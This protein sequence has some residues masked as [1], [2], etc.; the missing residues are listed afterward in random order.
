M[1][2]S[3]CRVTMRDGVQ[4]YTSVIKPQEKGK[5]PIVLIRNPYSVRGGTQETVDDLLNGPLKTE[6]TDF[7]ENGYCLVIQHC[8]GTGSSEGE[9]VHSLKECDDACDTLDWIRRQDFYAKEIYRFGGSYLGF[10]SLVDA[11]MHHEDVKGAVVYAP[12]M[13]FDLSQ[14]NGVFDIGWRGLW[15]A[16]MESTCAEKKGEINKDLNMFRTFPQRDWGKLLVGHEDY[17]FTI[18]NAHPFHD[19]PF[20]RSPEAPG[21]EIYESLETLQIPT[22]FISG[23]FDVF[24]MSNQKAW[25]E[26]IPKEIRSKCA[27]IIHPYGHST[28]HIQEQ[29]AAFEMDGSEMTTLSQHYAVNWFNHLRVGEPLQNVKEG[30]I[31]FFPEA[32]QNKWYYEK[33]PLSEGEEMKTYFLNIGRVLGDVPDKTEEITFLYNPYNPAI[34]VSPCERANGAPGF[35]RSKYEPFDPIMQEQDVPNSRYDIISFTGKKITEHCFV[36]GAIRGRLIVKSDCEDT[37]FY[38]RVCIVKDGVTYGVRDDIRTLCHELG[39]Y[40]PGE[41]VNLDF[42][43]TPIVWELF[44]GDELR[45]DVSSSCFPH[46]APHTNVKAAAQADVEHPKYA[47][48]TILCGKSYITVPICENLDDLESISKTKVKL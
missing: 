10:T 28:N 4:L 42:E 27:M 12:C 44:P 19:D 20:W 5:F 1:I 13:W 41:T 18:N 24:T 7:I 6:L 25:N 26:M 45:V 8:R 21:F 3:S 31:V 2:T 15:T 38:V 22:L 48:N 17:M 23:W 32:G 14:V 9:H 43:M 33:G 34:F 47:H 40:V 29:W 46:F 11:K 16:T 37:C 39:D 35:A 30:Q 36:K